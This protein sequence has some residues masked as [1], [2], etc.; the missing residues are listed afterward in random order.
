MSK[1]GGAPKDTTTTTK[2]VW[3]GDTTKMRKG[4]FDLTNQ[5]ID[6]NKPKT[7]EQFQAEIASVQAKTKATQANLDKYAK[8][9]ASGKSLNPEQAARQKKW[10]EELASANSK[11]TALQGGQETQGEQNTLNN[12]YGDQLDTRGDLLNAQAGNVASVYDKILG[13]SYDTNFNPVD[14]ASIS[15]IT[16][17]PTT[18][19]TQSAKAEQAS[20][21][22]GSYESPEFKKLADYIAAIAQNSPDYQSAVA[23]L[24]PDYKGVAVE[25]N[26]IY[27]GASASISDLSNSAKELGA[28]DPTTALQRLL[29]GQIDNPYL[30]SINQ[31]NINQSMQGYNDMLQNLNQQVMPGINNDAFAAGQYGGSRQG[32]AQG[33]ALQQ[34]EQNARDLAQSNVTAGNQ[35]FGNAYQNAQ[36]NMY[37]TANSLMSLAGQNSQFNANS[38]NDIAKLNANNNLQNEQFG[39]TNI[40]DILKFN[41]NNN[42][43]NSQFNTTN[44]NNMAQLNANNLLQKGQFDTGQQN[45]MNQFNANNL[46]Q[47]NQYGANLE[48]QFGL[49][50]AKNAADVST[51]NAGFA[52]QAGIT[53]ANNSLSQSQFNA[54]ASNTAALQDSNSMMS[55][56]LNNMQQSNTMSQFNADLGLQ[57]NTQQMGQTTQNLQNALTGLNTGQ[58]GLTALSAGQDSIYGAQNSLLNYDNNK[59][60]DLIDVGTRAASMT[61][62]N[63]TTT[64]IGGATGGNNLLGQIGG[65][66]LTAGALYSMVK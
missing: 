59:M 49:S 45:T 10:Q 62:G 18:D 54:G 52:T 39:A 32:I 57:N 36:Q 37:G 35:L 46:M 50:N 40:N 47:N 1:G 9:V 55:A 30:S 61:P 11:V 16:E 2:V 17:T 25:T 23:S 33:L 51:A 3:D 38:L 20:S 43:Q 14:N 8:Y 7:P 6:A 64:S 31:G 42:L 13:G 15:T 28:I 24:S 12:E 27:N 48:N 65:T 22:A 66:A 4:V 26:P 21:G 60:L 44:L 29:S 19:V 56:L 63:T 34:A 41:A 5:F 53:N 58:A